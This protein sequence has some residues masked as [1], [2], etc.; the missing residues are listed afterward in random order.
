[1]D[2]RLDPELEALQ[3]ELGALDAVLVEAVNSSEMIRNLA[4]ERL[5]T[6]MQFLGPTPGV[7]P[8][9]GRAL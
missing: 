7:C 1:M 9:C 6:G 3:A 2:R 8:G 4:R 5:P